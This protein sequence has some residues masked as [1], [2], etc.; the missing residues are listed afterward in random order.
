MKKALSLL[1]ALVLCLSLCACG[2]SSSPAIITNNNGET[3]ELTAKH[4]IELFESNE[5]K[6]DQQYESCPITIESTI[7]KIEGDSFYLNGVNYASFILH[8]DGGWDVEILQSVYDEKYSNLEVGDTVKITSKIY[9]CSTLNEV[10][11]ISNIHT[12][13]MG[14]KV[15]GTDI[16]VIG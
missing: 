11:Q 1:L 13:G 14:G 15:D 5:A 3:E 10:V 2:N 12:D 9:H 8:L 4:L 16:E 6:F 7:K